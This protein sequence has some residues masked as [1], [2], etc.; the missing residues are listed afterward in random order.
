MRLKLTVDSTDAVATASAHLAPGASASR[1]FSI[2][3]VRQI[4]H[5]TPPAEVLALYAQR[6]VRIHPSGPFR[7]SWAPLVKLRRAAH[8]SSSARSIRTG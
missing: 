6:L 7:V 3:E 8:S 2:I 4:P 1:G 5:G